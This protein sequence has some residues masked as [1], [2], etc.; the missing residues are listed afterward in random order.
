MQAAVPAIMKHSSISH[1]VQPRASDRP[2]PC[3]GCSPVLL[4][5]NNRAHAQAAITAVKA[6]CLLQNKAVVIRER[7]QGDTPVI[8]VG[9]RINDAPALATAI[10]RGSRHRSARR[11]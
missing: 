8:M 9:D 11:R 2:L 4:T 3:S 7:K 1:G 5:C 10:P 6:A